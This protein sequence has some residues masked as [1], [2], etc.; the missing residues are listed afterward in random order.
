[1]TL[2]CRVA[3]NMFWLNR[4]VER[5][6]SIIRVIDVTAHLELDAGDSG[7]HALGFWTPLLG[8]ALHTVPRAGSVPEPEDVRYFLAFDADNANSLLSCVRGARA[9]A[10]QVRD[11]LS[12]EMWEQVNTI[13]L[14]LV[15]PRSAVELEDDLHGFSRRTRDR[16]LLLQGLADA[17]MAHDEAWQFLSLGMYLERAD[18]ISRLLE[19]QSRLLTSDMVAE[20]D[21]GTVRWLAVLRSAGSAEAYA[22]YYSLRVEPLRVLEFLLLNPTFPQAVSFSLSAAW[23]ALQAISHLSSVHS[24]AP[25]RGLVRV[26]ASLEHASVDEVLEFGLEDFLQRMRADIAEVSDHITRAYFR[27]APLGDRH[28]TLARAAQIMAAQQQQQ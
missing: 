21:S 28:Q 19:R 14:G 7:M 9:A 17:T 16:L 25:L 13:Y 24:E 4:Y 10:R 2:L 11:S 22:H 18:N 15:D 12:S 23:R 6:L 27:F 3:E 26:R 5:A 8:P 20:H 1:M